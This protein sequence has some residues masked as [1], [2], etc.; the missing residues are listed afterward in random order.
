MTSSVDIRNTEGIEPSEQHWSTRS[1]WSHERL[2]VAVAAI[3]VLTASAVPGLGLAITSGAALLGVAAVLRHQRTTAR[4]CLTAMSLVPWLIVRD[5]RWLA[6]TIVATVALVGTLGAI[7]GATGR[8]IDDLS[9]GA[10]TRLNRQRR[11]PRIR[12]S[13]TDMSTGVVRSVLIG[14]GIALP[15][16]MVFYQLLASADA[17]FNS[18]IDPSVLPRVRLISFAVVAPLSL[19]VARFGSNGSS[20]LDGAKRERFGVLESTIVL[21]AVSALFAAFI[22]ARLSTIGQPLENAALRGE[23]REGFFQLLWVVALTVVLVLVLRAVSGESVLDPRVR[24]IGRL[25][26]IL[27]AVIDVLA[28]MR[29]SQYIDQTFHTPLRFWSFG[30]GV[31]LLAVL[32]LAAVR[33]GSFRSETR[34]FTGAL[35]TTW[36]GFVL[37]VAIVN[38]DERIAR[39]N[40]ENATSSQV[41]WVA[42]NNLISLSEDATPVI[43]EN[44]DVLRPMPNARFE[45]MAA[46][47]CAAES[48][49]YP[50]GFNLSRRNAGQVVAELCS[51]D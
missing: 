26:I 17:V 22:A 29:I 39:H 6:L 36:V 27:A 49:D 15:V 24:R 5:N 21:G 46:H 33:L 43:V 23:V 28:L 7:A 12:P 19:G 2:A 32:A 4:W 47:L 45:R 34:W 9:F 50:R 11:Q 31:W 14:V 16:V 30:F 18:W 25:A 10:L 40:F 42:V 8:S 13:G 44:I 51:A 20:D 41:E 3:G 48:D 1:V 37:V 38:P 35:V